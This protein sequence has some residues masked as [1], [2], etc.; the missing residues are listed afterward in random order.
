[1]SEQKN[2]TIRLLKGHLLRWM[3]HLSLTFQWSMPASLLS[4]AM[5]CNVH[6]ILWIKLHSKSPHQRS[7]TCLSSIYSSIWKVLA[8]CPQVLN[9]LAVAWFLA[10]KEHYLQVIFLEQKDVILLSATLSISRRM[11]TL[12]RRYV[13]LKTDWKKLAFKCSRWLRMRLP[14]WILSISSTTIRQVIIITNTREIFLVSGLDSTEYRI[15]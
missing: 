10:L 3:R 12:C 7:Y 11:H 9:Q 5:M 15:V 2:F 1:M 8:N 13:R 4:N 14:E 6:A